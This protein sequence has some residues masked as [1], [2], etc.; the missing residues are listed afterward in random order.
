MSTTSPQQ[1]AL[2]LRSAC[3]LLAMGTLATVAKQT[4]EAAKRKGFMQPFV[5]DPAALHVTPY[6]GKP[7]SWQADQPLQVQPAALLP[8]EY[9]TAALIRRITPTMACWQRLA[10]L[11][12]L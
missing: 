10:K 4:Q 1:L 12:L 11:P 8:P 6:Q 2:F 3:Q 5:L 7:Q 9:R